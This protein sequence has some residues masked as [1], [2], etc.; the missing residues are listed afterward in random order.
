MGDFI[1]SL[2]DDTL[3]RLESA[4]AECHRAEA[5]R[6][7]TDDCTSE[8]M[9]LSSDCEASVERCRIAAI[10]LSEGTLKGLVDAICLAQTD[11][12]DLLM[13]AGFGEDV[14]AHLEWWP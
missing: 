14:L 2:T 7:L 4:F 5:I 3:A 13:A 1:S 12:R 10:K 6:L 9:H 8:S 11:Y